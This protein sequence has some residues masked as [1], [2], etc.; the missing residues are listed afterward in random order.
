MTTREV[1]H[2]ITVRA[3]ASEVYRLLAEVE[4]WPRL[5]PPSVHVEQLEADGDQERIRIWATANG[6]AKSWT[7]IRVLDP[8]GLRI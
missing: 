2:E 3:A 7:S 6:E 8:E 4:N 5:F 1:E